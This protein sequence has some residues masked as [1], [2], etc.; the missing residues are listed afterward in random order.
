M[1]PLAASTPL[2]SNS[3][4]PRKSPMFF[5]R[6][7]PAYDRSRRQYL[8]LINRAPKI[9]AAVYALIDRFPVVEFSLPLL[10]PVLQ[11]LADLL[12]EKQPRVVVSVYPMYNYLVARLY[13]QSGGID[14]SSCTP[15][16]LIRS[17]SIASG[18]A[19]RATRSLCPTRRAPRCMRAQGVPA[20][21]IRDLGF[22]VLTAFR[23]RSPDPSP[24]PAPRKSRGCSS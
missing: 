10:A 16:S 13:P 6:S 7:V 24:C 14:H 23:P 2:A 17:P 5:P 15:S 21:I 22:P 8:E 18:I 11:A 9:W 3:G 1:P 20:E 12:A 19:R 4:S